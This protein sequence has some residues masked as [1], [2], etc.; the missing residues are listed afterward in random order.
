MRIEEYFTRMLVLIFGSLCERS[1]YYKHVFVATPPVLLVCVDKIEICFTIL[2]VI[3][4]ARAIFYVL[5]E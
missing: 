2:Y 3:I 5:F 4:V 1:L